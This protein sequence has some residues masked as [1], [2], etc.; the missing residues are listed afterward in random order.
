MGRLQEYEVVRVVR[1][2]HPPEH[3]DDWNQ[4]QRPPAIGDTGTI[5]NILQA[6]GL[7]DNYVVESCDRDGNTI[8]LGDFLAEELELDAPSTV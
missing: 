6:A 7:P 8:W 3:Y 1:L 2:L 5:V 4:N